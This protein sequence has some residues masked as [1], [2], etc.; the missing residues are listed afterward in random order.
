AITM[1]TPI[2]ALYAVADSRKSGPIVDMDRHVIIQKHRTCEPCVSK[3]C[4]YQKCMEN[5]SIE[6][7][8]DAV[9]GVFEREGAL[10]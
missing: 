1:G 7:V 2:V 4:R 8:F 9:R 5:I 10:G 3:R 6:E